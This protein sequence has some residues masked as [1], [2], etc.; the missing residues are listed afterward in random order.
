MRPIASFENGPPGK[1]LP[2]GLLNQPP[3]FQGR[4]RGRHTPGVQCG[5]LDDPVDLLG[6]LVENGEHPRFSIT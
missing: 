3:D 4:E 5:P 1:P 6:A 2:G